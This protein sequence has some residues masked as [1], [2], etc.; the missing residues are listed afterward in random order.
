MEGLSD[1]L[2]DE[3]GLRTYL[4]TQK[5]ASDAQAKREQLAKCR[6]AKATEQSPRISGP[7]LRKRFYSA[8]GKTCKITDG[9]R[10]QEIARNDREE[11]ENTVDRPISDQLSDLKRNQEFVKKQLAKGPKK[12]RP[13][14]TE[15]EAK[16]QMKAELAVIAV[17][18]KNL[19][20]MSSISKKQLALRRQREQPPYYQVPRGGPIYV[21]QQSGSAIEAVEPCQATVYHGFHTSGGN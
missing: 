15:E 18:E 17:Q 14:A 7:P 12:L 8:N 11:F 6:T 19:E 10:E 21:E 1:V 9:S 2:P 4:E 5:R 3:S 20:L 13:G 16:E